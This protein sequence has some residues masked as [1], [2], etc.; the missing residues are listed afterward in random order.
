MSWRPSNGRR[1]KAKT[2]R[3]IKVT[4]FADYVKNIHVVKI[5]CPVDYPGM[6]ERERRKMY[7]GIALIAE[8]FEEADARCEKNHNN[9]INRRK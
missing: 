8:A 7:E 4:K 2:Y 3:H 1:S 5:E 9:R 6:T